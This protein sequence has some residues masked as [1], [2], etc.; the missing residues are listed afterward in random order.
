MKRKVAVWGV[1]GAVLVGCLSW[2][3]VAQANQRAFTYTYEPET[4][5]QG[6]SEFEQWVTLKTLRN[7]AVGQ[8]RYNKWELREEFEYGVTD[9]YTAS[10]YINTSAE[11]YRDTTTGLPVSSFDFDGISLENRFKILSNEADGIGLTL[12]LEPRYSGSEAEIEGRIILGQRFNK[13]RWS[14]NLTQSTEWS[15]QLSV[16]TGEPE[17]DLGM[18]WQVAKHWL[19]GFELRNHSQI[20]S[21]KTWEN[22]AVFLG[23]VMSY[24]REA[25]WATLTVLP[26]LYGKN[27]DGNPDATTAFDLQNHER[28]N[29]RLIFGISF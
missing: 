8:D 24:D 4:M 29:V 17:L 19:A 18:T 11:N 27:F 16:L 14:L 25:W 20:K 26:Q 22:T 9:W 21:Y 7:K 6:V 28:L 2:G 23:P 3:G 10:L 12:Y 5:P 15:D 1:V 13:W